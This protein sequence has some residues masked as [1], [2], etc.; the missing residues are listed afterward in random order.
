MVLF[1][2][3]NNKKISKYIERTKKAVCLNVNAMFIKKPKTYNYCKFY[4]IMSVWFLRDCK[5]TK[6]LFE[7]KVL[8]FSKT[9]NIIEHITVSSIKQRLDFTFRTCKKYKEG[10]WNVILVAKHLKTHYKAANPCKI[11]RYRTSVKEFSD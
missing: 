4:K 8:T 7:K 11:R 9:C 10:Q 1:T 3:T 5:K 6:V 2:N